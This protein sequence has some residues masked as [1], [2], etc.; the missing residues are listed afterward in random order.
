V[1]LERGKCKCWAG[2][3]DVAGI[4]GLVGGGMEVVVLKAGGRFV[5]MFWF[6]SCSS[7]RKLRMGEGMLD[8]DL[9]CWG[10]RGTRV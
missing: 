10:A 3:A 7:C 1:L 8:W 6:K 9:E 2:G 5:K 4:E